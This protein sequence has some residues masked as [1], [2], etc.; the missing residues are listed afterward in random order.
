MGS[1]RKDFRCWCRGKSV[2]TGE[3]VYGHYVQ[4]LIDSEERPHIYPFPVDPNTSNHAYTPQP[5]ECKKGTIQRSTDISDSNGNA[6]YE[7]A[8]VRI[9]SGQVGK[10]GYWIGTWGVEVRESIDYD[11]LEDIVEKTMFGNPPHFLYNDN[12]ISFYELIENFCPEW[13]C[14]NTCTAVEIINTDEEVS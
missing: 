2:T 8:L 6:I 3:W 5:V 12:F 11:K 14:D 10:V 1:I 9:P 4:M 7:G 13:D